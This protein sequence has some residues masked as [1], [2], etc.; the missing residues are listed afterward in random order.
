MRRGTRTDRDTCPSTSW[1]LGVPFPHTGRKFCSKVTACRD[2]TRKDPSQDCNGCSPAPDVS[3]VFKC[4]GKMQFI[5][6]YLQAAFCAGDH[7]QGAPS[8]L[9]HVS[10]SRRIPS[11]PHCPCCPPAVL[12]PPLLMPDTFFPT[13]I[14]LFE[15]I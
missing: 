15:C 1:L 3:N 14:P 2:K 8:S 6:L 4:C 9:T 5:T 13:K 10:S 11:S 7:V 12:C